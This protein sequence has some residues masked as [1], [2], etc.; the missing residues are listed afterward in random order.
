MSERVRE[1]E[2]ERVREVVRFRLRGD[3][4]RYNS[5]RTVTF[6]TTLL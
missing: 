6:V 3:V 1:R 2:E 5:T 4:K